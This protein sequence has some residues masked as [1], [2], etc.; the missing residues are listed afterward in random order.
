MVNTFSK[1]SV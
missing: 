1:T